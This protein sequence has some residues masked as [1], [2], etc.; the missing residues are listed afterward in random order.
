MSASKLPREKEFCWQ[1]GVCLEYALLIKSPLSGQTNAMPM[2][3]GGDTYYI[4]V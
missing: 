2:E 1:F 3:G 4:L